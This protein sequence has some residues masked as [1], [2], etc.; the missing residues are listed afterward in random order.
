ML[1]LLFFSVQQRVT[2]SGLIVRLVVCGSSGRLSYLTLSHLSTGS[3][4]LTSSSTL[5]HLLSTR[6]STLGTCPDGSCTCVR[7][8]TFRGIFTPPR[9][10]TFNDLDLCRPDRNNVLVPLTGHLGRQTVDEGLSDGSALT[11]VVSESMG[12]PREKGRLWWC[13]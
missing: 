7:S 9:L 5:L 11:Y 4:T 12:R 6:F 8:G 13:H 1:S 3:T 2:L 10:D